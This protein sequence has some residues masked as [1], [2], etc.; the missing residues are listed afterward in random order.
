MKASLAATVVALLLS[1][2]AGRA[3][4][5]RFVLDP[6]ISPDGATIAFSYAGDV[7]TVPAS[8]GE[9]ARITD[10]VAYDGYPVWSPDGKRLA[11]ASDR[12]GSMD[13]FVVDAAGGDPVR[14]T[15]DSGG[16]IPCDWTPDGESI[17]F[18]CGS[19][20]CA[21]ARRSA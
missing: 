1:A 11:F 20:R 18:Q 17:L 10:H 5:I 7:W 4:E 14:L 3:E 12:F 2:A 19:P 8:G 13:L 6:E 15:F 21:A 9:A 16:D